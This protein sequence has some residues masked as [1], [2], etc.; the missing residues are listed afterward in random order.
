MFGDV[1]NGAVQ[2]TEVGRVV[3]NTWDALPR[4]YAG[5]ELDAF[6]VMPNHVHGIIV[7]PDSTQCSVGA[8][9]KP[10]QTQPAQTQPAQ[11]QPAQTRPAQTRPAQTQPTFNAGFGLSEV[12]RAFKT[13]SSRAANEWRDTPGVSVWQRNYYEHIIRS[14]DSLDRI[15]RYIVGNPLRWEHD[16]DNPNATRLNSPKAIL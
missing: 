3:C 8:G 13:F 14:G 7:L 2:L 9:F 15:R 10:A 4:H 16:R 12:I 1:V 5:I 11:T 6:V